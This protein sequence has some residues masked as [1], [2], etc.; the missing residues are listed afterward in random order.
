MM[1]ERI[2]DKI[3][4]WDAELDRWARG[5]SSRGF[6]VVLLRFGI[7]FLIVAIPAYSLFGCICFLTALFLLGLAL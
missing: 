6:V 7:I 4:E 5:S 3:D 2:L 1:I